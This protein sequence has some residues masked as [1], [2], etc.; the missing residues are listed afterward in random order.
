MAK[1][2][3][4]ADL[5]SVARKGFPV[6]VRVGPPFTQATLSWFWQRSWEVGKF[7][8]RVTAPDHGAIFD[9][10]SEGHVGCRQV[11]NVF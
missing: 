1:L 5:K 8:L 11:A 9:D 10:M 2:V 6:Q 4:A 3:Y 7:G